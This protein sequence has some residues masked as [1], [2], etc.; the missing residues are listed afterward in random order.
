M[1]RWWISSGDFIVFGVGNQ[2]DR[3]IT[4]GSTGKYTG[5]ERNRGLQDVVGELNPGF[6]GR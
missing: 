1:I 3:V 6:V 5:G 2:R 4:A